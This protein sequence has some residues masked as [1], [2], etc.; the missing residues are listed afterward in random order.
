MHKF[1][2]SIA[3]PSERSMKRSM[4]NPCKVDTRKSDKVSLEYQ[5]RWGNLLEVLLKPLAVWHVLYIEITFVRRG[6]AFRTCCIRNRCLLEVSPPTKHLKTLPPIICKLLGGGCLKVPQG[7]LR[8]PKWV[9]RPSGLPARASLV[10]A[11]NE[12]KQL[13]TVRTLYG[14]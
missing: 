12:V 8:Y 1:W 5:G 10:A 9:A 2:K 14:P 4:E 6:C 7:T 3:I 13:S 11:E